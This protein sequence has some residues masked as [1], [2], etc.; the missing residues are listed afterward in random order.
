M[1]AKYFSRASSHNCLKYCSLDMIN[2][3]NK[4]R[5]LIDGAVL[6]ELRDWLYDESKRSNQWKRLLD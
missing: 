2:L 1:D 3:S 6:L 4:G 5:V